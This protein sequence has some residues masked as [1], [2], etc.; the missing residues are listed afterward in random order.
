MEQ[1]TTQLQQIGGDAVGVLR[2]ILR[3]DRVPAS[4]R[5]TAARLVLEMAYRGIEIEEL[6]LRLEQLERRANGEAW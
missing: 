3:D 1:L 4:S 5:V 2:S 6:A